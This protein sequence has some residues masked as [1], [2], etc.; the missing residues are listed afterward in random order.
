MTIRNL[1][2]IAPMMFLA[3]LVSTTTVK[4]DDDLLSR[5]AAAESSATESVADINDEDLGMADVEALMNDGEEVDDEQA[6]A[7]CYRRFG[8]S[9]G[10]SSYGHRSY[11]YRSHSYR[12]CYTPTYYSSYHH[13]SPSYCYTPVTYTYCTPTYNNYWGCW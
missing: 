7:A 9:Y 4:A 1:F 11:G 8:R 2:A 10:Y 12:S 6:V 13:Y 3:A 5:L